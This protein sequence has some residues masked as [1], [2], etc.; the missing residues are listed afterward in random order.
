VLWL[1]HLIRPP[2]PICVYIEMVKPFRCG[3]ISNLRW[4]PRATLEPPIPRLHASQ[5]TGRL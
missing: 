1:S 2:P 3:G 5:P 4:W